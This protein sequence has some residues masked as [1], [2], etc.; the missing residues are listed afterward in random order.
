MAENKRRK[1]KDR[2]KATGMVLN[3]ERIPKQNAQ[4]RFREM[5]GRPCLAPGK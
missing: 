2:T 4:D 5:N 3:L 1:Y